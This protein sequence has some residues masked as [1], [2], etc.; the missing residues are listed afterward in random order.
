MFT[1]DKW[2]AVVRQLKLGKLLGV[3]RW[4]TYKYDFKPGKFDLNFIQ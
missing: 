2:Y 1:V 4:I 3:L